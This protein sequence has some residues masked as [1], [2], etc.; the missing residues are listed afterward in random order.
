VRRILLAASAVALSSSFASAADM[1]VKA[2]VYK[3]PPPAAVATW[4]GCYVGGN[5][6]G[7]WAHKSFFLTNDEGI[8]TAVYDGSHIASGWIGG[9]QIGCDYQLNNSWVIGIRGMGDWAGLTG[10]NFVGHGI[11]DQHVHTEVSAFGTLTGQ[12]GYLLIPNLELYALGGAAWI[13]DHHWLTI[14]LPA[15]IGTSSVADTTRT[16]YDIG[17]GLSWMFARNWD[18]W[19][20]YDHMDFGTKAVDFV[21]VAAGINVGK[22]SIF[23]VTQSMDK[24]LVGISYRFGMN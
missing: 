20:E 23:N 7:A 19:V 12:I 14:V 8:P 6:G 10:D 21:G 22:V 15:F 4:T 5:V 2:P 24:V 16:G 1:P 18:A 9:G 13:R 17:V 11:I 3:A